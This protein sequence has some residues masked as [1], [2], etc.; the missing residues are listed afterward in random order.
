[1][2]VKNNLATLG[3]LHSNALMKSQSP[4]A[5]KFKPLSEI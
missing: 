3:K 1:M 4:T 2:Y 5:F